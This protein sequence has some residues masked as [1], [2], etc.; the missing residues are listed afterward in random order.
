[1]KLEQNCRRKKIRFIKRVFLLWIVYAVIC[2]VIPPLFHKTT[3]GQE[4]VYNYGGEQQ[5]RVLSIDDNMDALLWR[6]RLINAA[7]ERIVL[8]TFDFWDDDLIIVWIK[9]S[10]LTAV[11]GV[12]AGSANVTSYM[13]GQKKRNYSFYLEYPFRREY[14]SVSNFIF[15]KSYINIDYLYGT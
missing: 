1:M 11:T 15:K 9:K 7:Q 10:D 2:V 3:A 13:A 12:S 6:L 5:E 14:M 4:T 8:C